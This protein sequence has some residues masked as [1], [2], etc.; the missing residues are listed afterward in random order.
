M[1]RDNLSLCFKCRT[2]KG[3]VGRDDGAHTAQRKECDNC[4]EVKSIPNEYQ[5]K[6]TQYKEAG[7]APTDMKDRGAYPN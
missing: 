5:P 3:F 7:I 1:K 4:K 2:N 6:G